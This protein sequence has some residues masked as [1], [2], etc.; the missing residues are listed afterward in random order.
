M[1]FRLELHSE[2]GNNKPELIFMDQV[3]EISSD[4]IQYKGEQSI[5]IRVND[6]SRDGRIILTN[7]VNN[8]TFEKKKLF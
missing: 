5:Q 1:H 8:Y 3:E 4:F 6:G 7:P 2:S